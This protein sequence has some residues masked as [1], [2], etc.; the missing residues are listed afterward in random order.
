[1][2]QIHGVIFSGAIQRGEITKIIVARQSFPILPPI[3]NTHYEVQG[4]GVSGVFYGET[5]LESNRSSSVI[6]DPKRLKIQHRESNVSPLDGLQRLQID[7][8]RMS[9]F[10]GASLGCSRSSFLQGDA[11]SH[12]VSSFGS[13]SGL[14]PDSPKS[15]NPDCYQRPIG[16]YGCVPFW[17]FLFSV[18]C[19]CLS[20]VIV[21]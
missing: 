4:R 9:H 13:L 15:D 14:L 21:Y 8:I 11:V 10:I 20:A 7:L 1:C 2:G 3:I 18:G 19:L 12:S 5:E 17:C 16:P 6:C